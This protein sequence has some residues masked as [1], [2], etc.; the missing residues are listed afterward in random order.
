MTQKQLGARL[1]L[2]EE[3]VDAFE[4]GKHRISGAVILGFTQQLNKPLAYFYPAM[5]QLEEAN[6]SNTGAACYHRETAMLVESIDDV[7]TLMSVT[8]FL[9]LAIDSL[10]QRG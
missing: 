3:Q 4:S 5:P 1:G 9:R 2:S 6:K 7:R 10:K 8:S